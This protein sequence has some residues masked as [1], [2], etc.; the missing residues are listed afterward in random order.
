MNKKSIVRLTDEERQTCTEVIKKLKGLRR[1]CVEP[2]FCWKPT[3]TPM[4]RR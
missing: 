4:A 2:K 3:P 1:K